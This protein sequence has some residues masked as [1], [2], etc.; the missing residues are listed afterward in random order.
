[1]DRNFYSTFYKSKL[2]EDIIPFWTRYSVDR[3]EGG[4]FT[5]L[6]RDGSVYDTDKFI[7]LQGRQVWMYA[8]LYN[9]VDNNSEWLDIA[10]HG[11]RFLLRHGRDQSGDWYFSLDRTGKP[12]TAAYSIFSDCF[13]CMAFGQLFTATRNESYRDTCLQTFQRIRS[14]IDNPKGKYSKKISNTRPLENIALPMIMSNL[15]MEI[16]AI[17]DP[18]LVES[19]IR[20]CADTIF[21]KFYDHRRGILLENVLPDGSFSDSMDGRLINP[22]HAIETAWF[23]MDVAEKLNDEN[24]LQKSIDLSRR[25]IEFGWDDEQGGILYFFDRLDKPMQQLEWDQKLWWVH[26]EALI[27][28]A[29]SY[30]IT[31][32]DIHKDWFLKLHD[33]TWDHFHDPEYGEFFGYLHRDGSL[34]NTSKGG[35]WKG[36]FHV[37]RAML[38]V[39]RIMES[40][41]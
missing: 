6:E 20:E 36:C 3:S 21:S 38:E 12:L 32:E 7:W 25:M 2:I 29:K 18:E 19:V 35:K 13:A 17:L 30:Q 1:M 10:E 33:Y 40:S 22:G 28:T 39:Y 8:K 11:A 26:C 4:F 37:P 27:A 15:C 5:C 31:G 24:L 23:L 41:M 16:E 34:L 14:R 9:V